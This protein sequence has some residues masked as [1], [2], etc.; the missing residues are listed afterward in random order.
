MTTPPI[1]LSKTAKLVEKATSFPQGVCNIVGQFCGTDIRLKWD[2]YI[3]RKYCNELFSYVGEDE[4]TEV[5]NSLELLY[6]TYTRYKVVLR[7]ASRLLVEP[8]DMFTVFDAPL[9]CKAK[10]SQHVF[11]STTCLDGVCLKPKDDSEN[12]ECANEV[13][14]LIAMNP[15]FEHDKE[16]HDFCW[17]PD[18]GEVVAVF[19]IRD[20]YLIYHSQWI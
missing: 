15:I 11:R 14:E 12:E 4:L 9:W 20:P 3:E 13:Q 7:T 17:D 2:T 19:I 8:I 1:L 5:T 10:Y 6:T 18:A 16:Q